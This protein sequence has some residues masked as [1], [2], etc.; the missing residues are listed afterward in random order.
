MWRRWSLPLTLAL[1][2][3][4]AALLFGQPDELLRYERAAVAGGA[5]WRLLTAHLTHLGWYHLAL[6]LAG[7]AVIWPLVGR[8]LQG[9]RGW[10]AAL[11]GSVGTTLGLYLLRPEI[12]WYVGLSGLLHGLL[13][14]G[15]VA[16]LRRERLEPSLLLAFLAAKLAWEQWAGPLPGSTLAGPVVVDSHLF[17]TLGGLLIGTLFLAAQS[18]RLSLTTHHRDTEETERNRS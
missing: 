16:A 17:G 11:G 5:V 7:L 18:P 10:L 4:A 3:L 9:G 6:N 2:S 12:L 13:A 14:A 15:A 1:L 8:Y